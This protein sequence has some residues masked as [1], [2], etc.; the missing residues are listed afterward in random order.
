MDLRKTKRKRSEHEESSEDMYFRLSFPKERSTPDEDT[1]YSCNSSEDSNY[2]PESEI[3]PRSFLEGTEPQDYIKIELDSTNP[4]IMPQE[5]VVYGYEN[6]SFGQKF[7]KPDKTVQPQTLNSNMSK[8]SISPERTFAQ[9]IST[10]SSNTECGSIHDLEIPESSNNVDQTEDNLVNSCQSEFMDLSSFR[11]TKLPP[12]TQT[13]GHR[14]DEIS[15]YV[16]T[17]NFEPGYISNLQFNVRP[18]TRNVG[19]ISSI[20]PEQESQFSYENPKSPSSST[21]SPTVNLDIELSSSPEPDLARDHPYK[22]LCRSCDI[23]FRSLTPLLTH[24][25][26]H[27]NLDTLIC[28][29]C[30]RRLSNVS[31]IQNHISKHSKVETVFCEYCSMVF[32][33]VKFL[34]DH[35]INNVHGVTHDCHACPMKFCSKTG[36]DLHLQTHRQ[37]LINVYKKKTHSLKKRLKLKH[38]LS[39]KVAQLCQAQIANN[40]QITMSVPQSDVETAEPS[41]KSPSN[42]PGNQ[43]ALCC[44]ICSRSFK[45]EQHLA[46]HVFYHKSQKEFTCAHCKNVFFSRDIFKTHK[47][48]CGSKLRKTQIYMNQMENRKKPSTCPSCLRLFPKR[49]LLVKHISQ[50]SCSNLYES[51]EADGLTKPDEVESFKKSFVCPDCDKIYK[52]KK[53]FRQH[54]CRKKTTK[55]LPDVKCQQDTDLEKS[56]QILEAKP[57]N[58]EEL[59]CTCCSSIFLTKE[60]LIDHKQNDCP[61]CIP[62]E[63]AVTCKVCYFCPNCTESFPTEELLDIHFCDLCPGRPS[64]KYQPRWKRF[65]QEQ[66]QQ[67]NI[68]DDTPS[69]FICDFCG[70]S[71][72]YLS[73][74]QKHVMRRVCMTS[75]LQKN[76]SLDKYREQ[77]M[78]R[79]PYTCENCK[80]SLVSKASLQRHTRRDHCQISDSNSLDFVIER[81]ISMDEV[82]DQ[83]VESYETITD[84]INQS[85]DTDQSSELI[86]EIVKEKENSYNFICVYCNERFSNLKSFRSHVEVGICMMKSTLFDGWKVCS[87]CKKLF[88][89][90]RNVRRHLKKSCKFFKNPSPE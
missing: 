90:V 69:G 67:S 80:I 82:H 25:R 40:P 51:D 14:I 83:S 52:N 30:K 41:R 10:E 61:D 89:S 49:S 9:S 23:E 34:E 43:A 1:F 13:T 77:T 44:P 65:P 73:S 26:S 31:E 78:E 22:C 35:M 20:L 57:P 81:E 62:T 15:R 50:G 55:T 87:G 59:V 16:L 33:G 60:K 47:L 68:I 12:C 28:E 21:T 46:A 39:K 63:Y 17:P 8:L 56:A 11:M 32:S 54:S 64:K 2:N 76:N 84:N 75:P 85:D 36:Y 42:D 7:R 45:M 18:N 37:Q 70:E 24:L 72:L 88:C 74:L 19:T 27:I 48:N 4:D 86:S 66:Q 38:T 71:L 53:T 5:V 6:A 79:L 29:I 3:Q 58:S